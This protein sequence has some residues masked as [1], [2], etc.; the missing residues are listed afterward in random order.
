[1]VSCMDL[2]QQLTSFMFGVSIHHRGRQLFIHIMLHIALPL[3]APHPPHFL[4]GLVYPRSL[5]ERGLFP[6]P[7]NISIVREQNPPKLPPFSC[8][9]SLWSSAL[10]VMS[11]HP[12]FSMPDRVHD[13]VGRLAHL[14]S[15]LVRTLVSRAP[16]STRNWLKAGGEVKVAGFKGW[17]QLYLPCLC[18]RFMYEIQCIINMSQLKIWTPCSFLT[19]NYT[20]STQM[21][22]L[23]KIRKMKQNMWTLSHLWAKL[24]EE[25]AEEKAI[26]IVYRV[27]KGHLTTNLLL[28]HYSPCQIRYSY[29]GLGLHTGITK[30]KSLKKSCIIKQKL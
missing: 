22:K 17:C 12:S 7:V 30:C 18:F 15:I 2:Q 6:H 13:T 20:C 16:V 14:W 1:M 4:L 25:G 5:G 26:S 9:C 28:K 27:V 23:N 10:V 19:K 29:C 21:T 24:Q 8:P 3:R 11:V